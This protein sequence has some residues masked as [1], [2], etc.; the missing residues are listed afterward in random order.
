M[1]T[2]DIKELN[3]KKIVA[4]DIDDSEGQIQITTECGRV[5]RFYHAQ[6][7]CESVRIE[8][9]QDGDGNLLSLIGKEIQ[10][11]D[12]KAETSGDPPP[13]YPDSWTRTTITFKT[14]SETIVSRWIGESNGFY[15]ESVD[16][17]EIF[18]Q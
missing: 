16:L 1:K 3:G 4:I 15:S 17:V 8:P 10:E 12:L 2:I 14:D 18:K 9:S 11:I 5:F 6:D 13:E 7:C